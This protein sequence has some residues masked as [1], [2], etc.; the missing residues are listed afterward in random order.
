M[1]KKGGMQLR[2]VPDIPVLHQLLSKAVQKGGEKQYAAWRNP[3]NLL[4]TLE[5]VST[6]KERKLIWSLSVEK[7]GRKIEL[8]QCAGHDILMVYNQVNAA[9]LNATAA[10]TR[11]DDNTRLNRTKEARS[12]ALE[13]LQPGGSEPNVVAPQSRPGGAARQPEEMR[14]QPQPEVRPVPA[15]NPPRQ[16]PPPQPARPA[17][18]AQEPARPAQPEPEPPR[19]YFKEVE[20]Q[21]SQPEIAPV[22]P[23]APEF[24]NVSAPSA[25]RPAPSGPAGQPSQT[26][27]AP[28]PAEPYQ[29][30]PQQKPNAPQAAPA[31]LAPLDS[32]GG[33]GIPVIG[34]PVQVPVQAQPPSAPVQP[35]PS[36]PAEAQ[37]VPESGS[38]KQISL[39]KLLRLYKAAR[40]SG[41]LRLDTQDAAAVIYLHEGET[42]QALMGE[43]KGDEALTEILLMS[44]GQFVLSRG[45]STANAARNIET[46]PEVLLANHKQMAYL[47]K[48]LQDYGMQANST[49]VRSDASLTKEEFLRIASQEAPM[50]PEIMSKLYIKLDGKQTLAE[51]AKTAGL[52]R[53]RLIEALYHMVSFELVDIYM[54]PAA[55]RQLVVTPKKIDGAMIQSVM[56]SLR[57]EDTGLFIYPAFLYFLEEEFFRVYRAR[58]TMT[59]IVFEM[60]DEVNTDGGVKRRVLPSVA[61]ADAAG[62]IAGRKRHTDVV[63]HYEAYDYAVVLPGTGSAGTKVFIKKIIKALTETPLA[64]MDGRKLVIAFGTATIPEDF[65]NLNSMLGAA[66]LALEQARNQGKV[67]VQYRD[68]LS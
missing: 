35:A 22:K 29:Q 55:P 52:S 34:N 58:G 19:S 6:L 45:I 18:A 31:P 8:C 48:E 61:I 47:L 36:R 16:T 25:G 9:A 50:D 60:R 27:Q 24:K 21:R 14:P 10:A 12:A 23:K 63:A 56:M 13:K 57:R 39:V 11:P 2:N 51:L 37:D 3:D 7:S 4:L 1:I 67:L 17:A 46:P 33:F 53:L 59:V 62:R 66:E 15:A 65:T 54:P 26:P 40:V 38:L 49:F 42:L 68:L 28:Q 30:T 44:D 5:V 32:T 41:R 20:R 64:G 43:L